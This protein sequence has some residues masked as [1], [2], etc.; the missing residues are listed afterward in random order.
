[1]LT[2]NGIP[3]T[4]AVDAMPRIWAARRPIPRAEMSVI[5]ACRSRAMLNGML[6]EWDGLKES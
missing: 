6:S 5:V 3:L 4:K 2:V 1:M